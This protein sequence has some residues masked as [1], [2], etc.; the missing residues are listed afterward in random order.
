MSTFYLTAKRSSQCCTQKSLNV[1]L[2]LGSFVKLLQ[3][4]DLSNSLIC[5]AGLKNDM[6]L[7]TVSTKG[8][9]PCTK[10]IQLETI[11]PLL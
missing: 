2:Y 10:F 1:F 9:L 7:S 5:W 3:V 6:A 8:G 4:E 11:E